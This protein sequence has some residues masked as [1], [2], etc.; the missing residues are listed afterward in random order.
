MNKILKEYF[1][2]LEEAI[3]NADTDRVTLITKRIQKEV[4]Y[5][6]DIRCNKCGGS[7][8]TDAPGQYGLIKQTVYG[9]YGSTALSDMMEYRFSMCEPCLSELFSLFVIPVTKRELI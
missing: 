4:A 9:G 6:E 5:E 1:N 7:C 2:S 8:K 3:E